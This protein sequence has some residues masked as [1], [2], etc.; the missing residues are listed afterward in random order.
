MFCANLFKEG[1]VCDRKT[2]DNLSPRA[3]KA[4]ITHCGERGCFVMRRHCVAI[5]NGGPMKG[6]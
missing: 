2:A 1:E 4:A 5:N 6:V 3:Y